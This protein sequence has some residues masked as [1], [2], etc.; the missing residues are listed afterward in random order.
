MRPTNVSLE[1]GNDHILVVDAVI[2]V[3]ENC[4]RLVLFVPLIK[5][6]DVSTKDLLINVSVVFLPINVSVLVGSVKTPVLTIVE[7][8]GLVNV[9][10]VSV[11]IE[12]RV[13]RVSVISGIVITLFEV[14][15][16]VNVSVVAVVADDEE[17]AILLVLS[18]LSTKNTD[19]LFKDLFVKISVV[20]RPMRVSEVVG[21]VRVP[22]LTIVAIIG[23]VSV[24]FVSV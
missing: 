16:D 24:L 12:V 11:C 20:E 14:V 10:L 6:R 8:I 3:K 19:V 2:F 7:N 9:L 23:V 5:K 17:Y 13:T 15:I 21:N 22:V 18:V 1:S 4:T